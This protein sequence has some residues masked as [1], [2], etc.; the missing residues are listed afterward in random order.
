MQEGVAQDPLQGGDDRPVVPLALECLLKVEL[1]AAH[2]HLGALQVAQRPGVVPVRVG[3]QRP[4]HRERVEPGRGH[5]GHHRRLR[6]R[7]AGDQVGEGA[8][9]AEVG[10]HRPGEGQT[11]YPPQ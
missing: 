3:D 6:L 11:P 9:V 8:H 1:G 5:R 10:A 2:L 7:A 4:L